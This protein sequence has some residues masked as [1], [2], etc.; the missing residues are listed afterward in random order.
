MKWKPEI[1]NIHNESP[2]S[3]TRPQPQFSFFE[4]NKMETPTPEPWHED[5]IKNGVIS[6]HS[7]ESTTKF[8]FSKHDGLLLLAMASLSLMAAL[9]GTSIS[10]ALPVS[11]QS[12][13]LPHLGIP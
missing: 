1:H 8:S 12:S 13:P 2:K 11:N 6:E 9:D 4:V 7:V 3:L 5:D 10:V